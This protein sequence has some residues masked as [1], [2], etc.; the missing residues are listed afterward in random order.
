MERPAWTYGLGQRGGRNF[1]CVPCRQ[2][3]KTFKVTLHQSLDRRW[4]L[5]RLR[6]SLLVTS[7]HKAPRR[8]PAHGPHFAR[9]NR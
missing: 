1:V 9:A 6:S 8:S 5:D 4:P 7:G 2:S 3:I